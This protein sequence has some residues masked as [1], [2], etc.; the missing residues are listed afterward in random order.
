L[1]DRIDPKQKE[2]IN[3]TI[4]E[5]LEWLEANPNSNTQE[6]KEKQKEIHDKINPTIE[7][8]VAEKKIG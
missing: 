4:E 8:A 6:I 1:A 7:R 2:K 3:K 5:G